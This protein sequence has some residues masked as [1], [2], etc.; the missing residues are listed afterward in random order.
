MYNTC[1]EKVK[2]LGPELTKCGHNSTFVKHITTYLDSMTF[3]IPSKQ[4]LLVPLHQH[5]LKVFIQ[6]QAK[7]VVPLVS[8]SDLTWPR[9]QRKNRTSLM[10]NLYLL[11]WILGIEMFTLLPLEMSSQ[12]LNNG[13]VPDQIEETTGNIPTDFFVLHFFSVFHDKQQGGG[14]RSLNKS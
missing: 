3:R 7:T 4:P 6:V 14:M 9:L 13:S 12:I 10:T 11:V 1:L 8:S 5:A 2:C